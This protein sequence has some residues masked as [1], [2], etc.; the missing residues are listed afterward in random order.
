MNAYK[1]DKRKEN[2]IVH[3]VPVSDK[4]RTAIKYSAKATIN[5]QN[6]KPNLL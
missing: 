6:V 1:R 2:P 5:W 3:T 4:G